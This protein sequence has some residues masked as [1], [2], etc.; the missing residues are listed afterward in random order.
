MRYYINPE[1]RK[2]T[3][4]F[5][6]HI[7]Y[8]RVKD[9]EGNALNLELSI[10]SMSGNSGLKAAAADAKETEGACLKLER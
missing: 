3:V 8:S 5:T 10:M 6:D 2:K 9:L 1:R 7:V 4:N